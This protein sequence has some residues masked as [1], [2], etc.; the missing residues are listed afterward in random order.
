MSNPSARR[1]VPAFV[2]LLLLLIVLSFAAGVLL[3][4]SGLSRPDPADIPQPP[5]DALTA[6]AQAGR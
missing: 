4:T 1:R 6:T 2:W 5:P 3:W